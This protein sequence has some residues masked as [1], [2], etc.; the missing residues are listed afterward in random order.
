VNSPNREDP[1]DM[2]AWWLMR[3][4][5]QSLTASERARMD[6]WLRADPAHQAAYVHVRDV[7]NALDVHERHPTFDGLRQAALQ[8]FDQ[9]TRTVARRRRVGGFA[10]AALAACLVLGLFVESDRG[11][12]DWASEILELTGGGTQTYRTMVGERSSVVL[13]D[14]SELTLN[15]GSRVRVAY[16][17]AERRIELLEGEALFDVAPNKARPF[18]VF[19]GQRKITAVGTSFD[20]R[21]PVDG[22]PLNV[23]LLEG[24]V[25]IDPVADVAP[26]TAGA[27]QRP[28]RAELKAGERLLAEASGAMR[29]ERIDTTRATAWRDGRLIADNIELAELVREANRYSKVKLVITDP[30]LAKLKVGGVFKLGHAQMI[31]ENLAGFLP[32]QHRVDG[33]R[34]LLL[35]R[36]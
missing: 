22:T 19:A 10:T 9:R 20:V 34:V 5:A 15:T 6:A 33:E 24:H 11:G 36:S 32:I 12:R 8:Q 25:V 7:V 28:D 29:V 3:E 35:P 18:I 4:T 21:L 30:A 23:T 31:A 26:M 13:A 16:T 14:G 1:D 17:D 27:G 2:A